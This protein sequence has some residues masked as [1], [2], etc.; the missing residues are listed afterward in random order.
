M[1]QTAGRFQ[2]EITVRKQVNLD[3]LLHL[4]EDYHFDQEKAYPL[5]LFLHGVGERGNNVEFLKRNGLPK[6]AETKELPF[7]LLSP[8][9]PNYVEQPGNFFAAQI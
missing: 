1:K 2:E 4:P 7:I 5:V 9:C 6:L 8:Q 3:Y